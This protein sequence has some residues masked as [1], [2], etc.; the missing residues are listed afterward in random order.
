MSGA[1]SSLLTDAPHRELEG[2]ANWVD[3][4]SQENGINYLERE[5]VTNL[6]EE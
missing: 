2:I 4:A 6:Q 1:S 5:Y 3:V